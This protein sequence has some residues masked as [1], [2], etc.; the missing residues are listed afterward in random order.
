MGTVWVWHDKCESD[1]AT[2]CKSNGKDTFQ[3]LSG[4][5]WQGNNLGAAWARH[6]MCGSALTSN[7][8]SSS[9]VDPSPQYS[10][11]SLRLRKFFVVGY[12]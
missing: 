5:A 4:R 11:K 1:T 3:N 6:P 9:E 8:T 12:N 10:T 7:C 2:L